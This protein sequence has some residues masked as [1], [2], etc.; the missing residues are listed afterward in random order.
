L[1]TPIS[2]LRAP[3]DGGVD[4]DT[5]EAEEHLDTSPS[6]NLDADHDNAPLKL[7][8]MDDILGPSSPPG[9]AVREVPGQLFMLQRSRVASVRL[10]RMPHGGMQ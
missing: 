9:R 7:R 10:R 6:C 3:G 4:S 8:K 5:H 1:G 2:D